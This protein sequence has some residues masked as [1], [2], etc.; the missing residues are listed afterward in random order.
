M[1]DLRPVLTSTVS[2]L[3]HQ[4]HPRQVSASATL[5]SLQNAV[6]MVPSREQEMGNRM[7]DCYSK[8]ESLKILKKAVGNHDGPV[9]ALQA[10]VESLYTGGMLGA[11]NRHRKAVAVSHRIMGFSSGVENVGRVRKGVGKNKHNQ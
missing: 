8:K 3:L 6:N 5:K 2:R 1:V 9:K 10:G 7:G 4:R 11:S